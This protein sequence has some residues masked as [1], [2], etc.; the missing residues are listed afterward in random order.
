MKPEKMTFVIDNLGKAIDHIS[1][2]QTKDLPRMA[3]Y[4]FWFEAIA[5]EIGYKENEFLD[6]YDENRRT[7]NSE[8]VDSNPLAFVIKKFVESINISG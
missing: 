5:R 2:L 1:P 4:A 3:D 8:I 7:Q 6:T